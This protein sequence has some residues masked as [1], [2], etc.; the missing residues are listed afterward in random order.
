MKFKLEESMKIFF[1]Y[2]I[3]WILVYET[4]WRQLLFHFIDF[5]SLYL[6]ISVC[7]FLAVSYI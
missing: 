2:K 3:K 4:S 1:K 6:F 7:L 5:I